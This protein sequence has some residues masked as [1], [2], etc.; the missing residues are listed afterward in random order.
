MTNF[1]KSKKKYN[2]GPK[3][4]TFLPHSCIHVNEIKTLHSYGC[5]IYCR[6]NISGGIFKENF[7]FTEKHRNQNIFLILKN[8]A[9]FKR[10]FFVTF[11]VWKTPPEVCW[12]YLQT[13]CILPE[14]FFNQNNVDIYFLL[15]ENDFSY[16][17]YVPT[18]K[19]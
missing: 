4:T 9:R 7:N 19:Q 14:F 16:F 2:F 12:I 10:N 17:S 15:P 13:P 11:E 1:Q 3:V 18:E 6:A 5:Q 8:R